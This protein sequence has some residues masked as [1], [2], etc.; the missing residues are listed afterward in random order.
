M[1]D[2]STSPSTTT[3]LI[4]NDPLCPCL[5]HLPLSP[6]GCLHC[7]VC[8]HPW[9]DL[10]SW[11]EPSLG[12]SR[13]IL[14]PPLGERYKVSHPSYCPLTTC[15]LTTVF[16]TFLSPCH[17]PSM[18]SLW[19]SWWNLLCNSFGLLSTKA[20]RK[21]EI[22]HPLPLHHHH[23]PPCPQRK[24]ILLVHMKPRCLPRP[25]FSWSD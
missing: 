24:T 15:P 23:Y 22:S 20:W 21:P 1:P 4:G 19:H 17:L 18:S 9:Q 11:K 13:S 16:Q 2:Q 7:L 14:T 3:I 10:Y 5:S 8:I 12:S 25:L 6:H